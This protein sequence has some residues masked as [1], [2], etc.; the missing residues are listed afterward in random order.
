[1]DH[2]V[3]ITAEEISHATNYSGPDH[4][5][6]EVESEK[7]QVRHFEG[8]GKDSG[9]HTQA[10]D[11]ARHE[12]RP[13]AV[14]QVVFFCAIEVPREKTEPLPIPLDQSF[15]AKASQTITQGIANCGA[16]DSG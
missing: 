4:G 16:R 2:P 5:A 13:L 1:M 7:T 14:F 12:Y 8:T 9:E 6:A 15:A 11:K 10:G 3:P